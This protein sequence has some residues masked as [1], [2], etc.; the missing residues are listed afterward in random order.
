VTF[1]FDHCQLG[2]KVAKSWNFPEGIL[3]AIHYHHIS[4]NYRG[5]NV[6]IVQCVEAADIICNLKN[7]TAVGKVMGKP[8]SA[9]IN[10]LGLDK[11][12]LLVLSQDLDRELENNKSLIQIGAGNNE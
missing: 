5:E 12:D 9:V 1:G 3:D 2:V 4:M 8:S 6:N 10:K 11:N 7:L